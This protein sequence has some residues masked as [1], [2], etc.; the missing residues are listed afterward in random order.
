VRALD[1]RGHPNRAAVLLYLCRC[2]T[3]RYTPSCT[4]AA[5]LSL[6]LPASRLFT[7]T[8][9]REF[10]PPAPATP[11]TPPVALFSAAVRVQSRAKGRSFSSPIRAFS[12]SLPCHGTCCLATVGPR[13]R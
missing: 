4:R 5:E 8:H 10:S 7:R 9:A 12:P 6:W 2:V 3:P 13:R 1:D 11:A